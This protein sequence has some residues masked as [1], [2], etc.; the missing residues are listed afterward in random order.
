[1]DR[2]I[3][4][5]DID[6][7]ILDE[8]TNKIP[9]SALEAIGKLK[10]NGHLA[11]I[12]TGRTKVILPELIKNSGFNGYI[13]GC[14]T[15]IECDGQVLLDNELGHALSKEIALDFKEFKLDAI[16]EG[17][18]F[19][20]FPEKSTIKHKEVLKLTV[21]LAE[22]GFSF[23]SLSQLDK[24]YFDKFVIFLNQ[25]SNFE[26]FYNKYKDKLDF[27]KRSDDFY[28]VVPKGFS[29]ATGIEFLI[30][31][32]N[33][34]HKNTFAIGDSTND[35]SMLEYAHTSIAMGNSNEA[36]LPLVSYVTTHINNDGIFNA[37]KHYKLI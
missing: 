16:G 6:G 14:G 34:P 28:E 35:L 8:E 20:Y 9:G 11:I 13:C 17:R 5:F 18:D 25:D 27:I 1:M 33:I 12:N 3:I 21:D 4:F 19:I 2:K 32:L 7:T 24:L 22:E 36:L 31:H 10:E 30:N 37:L 15:Y 26:G 23:K 29:K